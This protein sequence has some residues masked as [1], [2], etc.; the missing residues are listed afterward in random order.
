[1][2]EISKIV[3]LD[4]DAIVSWVTQKNEG[5]V[6]GSFEKMQGDALCASVCHFSLFHGKQRTNQDQVILP[7]KVNDN[8]NCFRLSVTQPTITRLCFGPTSASDKKL[9]QRPEKRQLQVIDENARHITQGQSS[10]SSVGLKI[11]HV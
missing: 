9:S 5:R 1:M 4:H 2:H 10:K 8:V 6:G 3:L 7:D 11:E